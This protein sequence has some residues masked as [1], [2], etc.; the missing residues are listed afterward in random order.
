[1]AQRA[2]GAGDTLAILVEIY[3]GSP[4]AGA[5]DLRL[6]VKSADGRVVFEKRDSAFAGAA[7][8]SR[9]MGYRA[10]IPIGQWGPET[11]LLS[12]EAAEHDSQVRVSRTIPFVVR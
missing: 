1:T 11:Y 9:T 10:A 4:A 2:F 5:L 6:L 8:T 3:D 12:F 7:G